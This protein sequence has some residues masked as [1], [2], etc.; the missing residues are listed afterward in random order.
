VTK[1]FDTVSHARIAHNLRKRKIPELLVCWVEDFLRER[2]TEIKVNN[3]VLPEAPQGSSISPILYLF[4]N[5]SFLKEYDDIRLRRSVTGFVDDVNILAFS[6]STEE[7]C[8]RLR[9]IHNKCLTWPR[10]MAPSSA[11]TNTS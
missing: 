9:E 1:A 4:Y 11:P 5:A 7:N 8:R 2:S 10:N 3:F 6:E